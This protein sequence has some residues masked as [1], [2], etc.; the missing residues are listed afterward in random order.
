MKIKNILVFFLILTVSAIVVLSTI[1]LSSRFFY[2]LLRK[3][4]EIDSIIEFIMIFFSLILLGLFNKPL[5]NSFIE[6]LSDE[7]KFNSILVFIVL[8]VI[9][10]MSI[11]LFGI[12]ILNIVRSF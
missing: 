6:L 4:T 9:K 12:A 8:F 11:I 3:Q 7:I 10:I 2:D 5:K 1:K